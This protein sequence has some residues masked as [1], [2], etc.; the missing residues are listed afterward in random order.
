VRNVSIE[1][2]REPWYTRP[3]GAA[4]G[5]RKDDGTTGLRVVVVPVTAPREGRAGCC[6]LE[7]AVLSGDSATAVDV[8]VPGLKD[9]TTG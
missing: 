8:G 5:M 1:L 9:S 3:I 4:D 6:L 2:A 7:V